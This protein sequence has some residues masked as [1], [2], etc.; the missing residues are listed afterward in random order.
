M[1]AKD[2]YKRVLM[3]ILRL[4]RLGGRTQNDKEDNPK[5]TML[6]KKVYECLY[7]GPAKFL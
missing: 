4:V 3:K 5:K 1:L 6:E 7:A 2:L